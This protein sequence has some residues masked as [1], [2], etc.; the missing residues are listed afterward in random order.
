MYNDCVKK[1]FGEVTNTSISSIINFTRSSIFRINFCFVSL[2][3]H[4]SE[5]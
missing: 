2:L 4:L 3:P 1:F 5:I